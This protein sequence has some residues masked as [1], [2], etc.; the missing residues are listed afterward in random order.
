MVAPGWRPSWSAG[1]AS[2]AQAG[3]ASGAGVAGCGSGAE[4][5][6]VSA[7]ARRRACRRRCARRRGRWDPR[8]QGPGRDRG[9]GPSAVPSRRGCRCRRRETSGAAAAGS[10]S[11]PA[12]AG[13]STGCAASRAGAP[14]PCPDGL[15]CVFPRRLRACELCCCTH[16]RP[17]AQPAATK[18]CTAGARQLARRHPF[19]GSVPVPTRTQRWASSCKAVGGCCTSVWR[20]RRQG[21]S[22]GKG[23]C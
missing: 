13:T 7:L 10:G 23:V 12:F 2:D 14:P 5:G 4:A 9:Y 17:T 11:R 21:R 15:N 22:A 3:F 1:F 18:S 8:G 19:T 6:S 16:P 20:T